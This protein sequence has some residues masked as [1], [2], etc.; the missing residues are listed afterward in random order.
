MTHNALALTLLLLALPAA[1]HAADVAAGQSPNLL[2][3][4]TDQQ[5]AGALSCAG[6][7][8]LKTPNLDRLAARGV[9]FEKSYC[10]YPLCSPSRGTLFTSRMPHE[11]SIYGN[12]D[13]ELSTKGVPTMGEL[14]QAAGYETA[15]A[16]KWHVQAPFPAFKQGK[17]PGFTVLP[18]AGKDPHS[19]DLT[20]EG[21]GLTVDPNTADAAIEF[22]RRSHD[23]PFLLT[24]SVLNPHDICEYTECAAF[25]EMLPADPAQLPPARPNL[26]D[27]DVLPSSL[28]KFA[29]QHAD[30]PELEWR[31]YLWIYYRLVEI[32]DAQVGRVLAVLD[33]T[34]LNSNTVVVFTSDHG[35]MMG[36][37]QMVTKQK[38]YE[39]SAA[40]PLIVASPGAAARVDRQH[41]V[42]GLDVLPTLLDYAGIAAPSSLEGLSLRPLL[43]G[44][45]VPWREFSVSETVS[46]AESRLVRTARYKYVLFAQGEN[47][48]QFFDMEA[49]PGET[50]NFIAE[51]SLAGE[52]ERHRS[53]LKQWMDDTQ[54]TFGKAS[55]AARSNKR[56]SPVGVPSKNKSGQQRKAA[57]D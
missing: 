51:A 2:F 50:K 37:H 32:A 6:N 11:L 3:I 31:E 24:V 19:L 34:G 21:K 13:A 10:T 46:A 52:I 55:A 20:K 4:I 47:R 40:V 7:P 49:D 9:R 38:L 30:W 39:E 33:E 17:I 5:T 57:T 28:Q 15:Y 14:F 48:E 26:R 22:L 36:S 41:L 54:D 43:E 45:A 18:L 8:Y 1:G 27:T 44:K 42:S 56:K 12:F 53:L 23:R 29:A 35:E 25:Q 16:G